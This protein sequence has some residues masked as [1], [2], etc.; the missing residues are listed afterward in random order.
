[1]RLT[2]I[3]I[4][5]IKTG[6]FAKPELEGSVVYLQA[7][8]FDESGKWQT[9]V[10]PDLRLDSQINKHLL[11]D[12]DVLFAAKGSKNFASVYRGSFRAVAS[13]T[14]FVIRIRESNILPEYLGWILNNSATRAFLKR[15]AIGS[16][17]V[18]IS[19]A[20]L[21]D[22]EISI[23]GIEKQKQILAISLLSNKEQNLRLRIAQLRQFQTQQAI[24]NAIR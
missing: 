3:E 9:A 1:M 23:P 12:G 16:A 2:L 14:F 15:H 5:D 19:K 18:S 21:G 20:V 13:T 6:I 10:Q 17:M 22:L 11:N 4:A 7:K 8:H 24:D